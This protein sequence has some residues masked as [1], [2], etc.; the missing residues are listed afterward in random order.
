[1][2]SAARSSPPD[3]PGR[4]L[5]YGA[6]LLCTLI[7]GSTFLVIRIGNDVA[8]PLWSAALRLALAAVILGAIMLATGQ[9]IPR[10]AVLRTAVVYGFLVF[11]V[12]FA[13]LYISETRVSS[14]VTAVIYATIPLTTIAFARWYGIEPFAPR[15]LAG[16]I[17]GLAGVAVIFLAEI[18]AQ[19]PLL[20]LGMA[21]L[22]ATAGALSG[23]ILKR[24]PSPSPVVT[25][26]IGSALGALI[27]GVT[28]LLAGERQIVPRTWAAWFPIVYLTLAGSVVAF[29]AF[30]W[31]LRHRSATRT[32]FISILVPVL[33]VILGHLVLGEELTRGTAIGTVLVIAG[34]VVALPSER[35]RA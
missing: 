5:T 3:A 18:T 15:R 11:G 21:F 2:R 35:P 22:G 27:C 20:Y 9:R 30:A 14:G 31:L 4:F 23:V 10:G 34:V 24:G 32:S 16:A 29:V 26:A 8:P 12:N 19:V 25:N 17:I 33:A 13:L 28:S 7:W 6:F 1:M